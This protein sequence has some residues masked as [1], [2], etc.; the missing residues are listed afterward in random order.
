[1][2][3]KLHLFLA[4][5]RE[6]GQCSAS[7][8]SR[9]TTEERG[10][11]N[12]WGRAKGLAPCGKEMISPFLFCRRI[13]VPATLFRIRVLKFTVKCIF[14]LWS[15]FFIYSSFYDAVNIYV[16]TTSNGNTSSEKRNWNTLERERNCPKWRCRPEIWLV[17]LKKWAIKPS[18]RVAGVAPD[19]S[20]TSHRA[21][22]VAPDLSNTSH[23]VAGVAPDLPNTSHRVAGVA[24]DLPHTSHI[25]Y[26]LF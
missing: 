12:P 16:N 24:P 10:P 3:L 21:A 20:N 14:C 9:F 22:G 19:L 13:T 2:E 8:P 18:V 26:R 15:I 11:D 6:E 4:L 7:H 1:M 5:K 17:K 23:R 25:H